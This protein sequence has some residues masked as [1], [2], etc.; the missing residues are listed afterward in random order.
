MSSLQVTL[1]AGAAGP[2]VI[3]AGEADQASRTQLDEVLDAQLSGQPAQLT[4]DVSRLRYADSSAIRALAAA[5]VILRYRGG[6]LI[7]MHPSAVNPED[8]RQDGRRP[9]AHHP[10]TDRGIGR[11]ARVQEFRLGAAPGAARADR[12]RAEQSRDRAGAVH[13][14]QT[15]AGRLR[16]ACHKLSIGSRGKLP[17]ALRS[18]APEPAS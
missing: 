13:N 8:A 1:A 4:I 3:L 10:R 16:R 7:L 17:A 5:A 2:V 15:V 18:A 14:A 9:G 12:G 6:N 11:S